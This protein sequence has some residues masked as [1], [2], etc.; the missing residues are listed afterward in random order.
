MTRGKRTGAPIDPTVAEQ[1][2]VLRRQ[3]AAEQQHSLRRAFQAEG[4][5]WDALTTTPGALSDYFDKRPPAAKKKSLAEHQA[6]T[7]AMATAITAAQQP[8][9]PAAPADR[10]AELQAELDAIQRAEWEAELRA[11][12]YNTEGDY[13]GDAEEGAGDEATLGL[14]PE[15]VEREPSLL[16]QGMTA[17]RSTSWRESPDDEGYNAYMRSQFGEPVSGDAA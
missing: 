6:E 10:K 12:G 3:A 2:A 15:Q 11:D 9:Q 17:A 4:A 8:V 14:V 16:E 5:A 7:A 1:A 13:V